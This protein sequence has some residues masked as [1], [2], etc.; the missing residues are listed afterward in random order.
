MNSEMSLFRRQPRMRRWV[1]KLCIGFGLPLVLMLVL[2]VA[3]PVW[4]QPASEP[5]QATQTT[6]DQ[7]DRIPVKLDNKTL[8]YVRVPVAGYSPETRAEAT[9]RRIQDFARDRSLDL[10]D[11]TVKIDEQT[12][13]YNLMVGDEPLA[14]LTEADAKAIGIDPVTMIYRN[15]LLVSEAVKDWRVDR[16]P[17]KYA[18]AA[19]HTLAAL[20]GLIVAL[21][22]LYWVCGWLIRRLRQW[23][24]TRIRGF[25]LFGSEILSAERVVDAV[26]ELIK[27]LR[28]VTLLLVLGYFLAI[29]LGFFPETR[30]LAENLNNYAFNAL[31]TV[32]LGLM[33]Y[34]PKLF[35]IGII[36][37]ITTYVLKLVKFFFT[38]V[39]RGHITIPGFYTNWAKPTYNII[40]VLI[41]FF[42]GAVAYPYL[43]GAS[44]P[45]FQGISIFV[46]ALFTLGSSGAI[47]NLVS[48]IVLIY[49]RAYEI[50][51]R[52]TISDTTGDVMEK[53]LFV[54]R[55][56]T[57]KNVVV[58]VPNAVILGGNVI[59]YTPGKDGLTLSP[60]VLHITVTLGYDVPWRL[61]HE[62][63][64]QAAQAT[65]HILNQ[66]APFVLQTSLDDFYVSYELNAYTE[67][68]KLMPKLYS[69]LHQNIQDR[70]N[71]LGIEILSPHY[72][73][74]RDGNQLAVPPEYW[75]E[76][77]QVPAFRVEQPAR[78]LNGQH[79]AE[80]KRPQDAELSQE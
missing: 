72:R 56:R 17:E 57:L 41:I 48:G 20:V 16:T 52:I 80:P 45:A 39:Q 37:L 46:G 53:S 74:A 8:F 25:S 60:L 62:V 49:S 34:M 58:T 10:G 79:S 1:R 50:G 28:L 15:R 31:E 23:Q 30:F 7:T 75:P 18:I 21:K 69:Q 19:G 2:I 14:I 44:S 77:Y 51:D 54:T 73:A 12:K 59:N 11:L 71:E 29:I 27:F 6:T 76:D 40:R 13:T 3:S 64:I 33:A 35:F 26:W 9:S 67:K 63:L 24:G 5:A 70:C 61:V 42:A 55:I 68:P 22:L 78:S 4:S 32:G 65:E 66:P 38:E 47:A 36:V 43:P